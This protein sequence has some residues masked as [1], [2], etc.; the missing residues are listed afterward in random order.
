MS[1]KCSIQST[2]VWQIHSLAGSTSAT[3]A[4]TDGLP[5]G[6]SDASAWG[7]NGVTADV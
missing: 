5:S 7:G 1:I 4:A 2:S 6:E 3:H